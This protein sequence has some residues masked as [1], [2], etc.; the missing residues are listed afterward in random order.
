MNFDAIVIGTATFDT[1]LKGF[2]HEIIVSNVFTNNK[3]LA[4]AY[5]SKEKVEILEYHTGGGAINI[6]SCMN[7]FGLRTNIITRIAKDYAGEFILKDLK[8]KK[9]IVNK[10]IQY[11]KKEETSSSV[12]LISGN[13]EKSILSHK[14]CSNNLELDKRILN[15]MKTKILIT[16]TLLG[17]EKNFEA[18]FEYKKKNPDVLLAAN[19]G[20]SDL[21]LL[22]NNLD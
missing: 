20:F 17:N 15:K 11:D 13:G 19:P 4:L 14:G 3:A 9:N 22:K 12:I 8:K 5:G 16:S 1:F 21:M 2:K 6:S 7:N 10:F 18:I